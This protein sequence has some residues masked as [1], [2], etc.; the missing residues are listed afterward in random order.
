MRQHAVEGASIGDVF[1]S[2][3]SRLTVLSKRP[4]TFV[5]CKSSIVSPHSPLP[6]RLSTRSEVKAVK[7]MKARL[8]LNWRLVLFSML[9]ISCSGCGKSETVESETTETA[10]SSSDAA[11]PAF[12]FEPHKRRSA[13]Q[14]EFP[15]PEFPDFVDVAADHGIDF[16]YDN[17]AS[18]KA[19]MVESTGGGCGWIDFDADGMTDLYLTQ[20]G[21]PC[22]DATISDSLFRQSISGSFQDRF[23]E[24]GLMDR[25]FGHGVAVGDFD[26][27]GFDDM[28]VANA[29]ENRLFRNMGDGTFIET[30]ADMQGG[31]TAWS[32]TVAW[33]DIDRD[34]DLDLYVCNYSIYDPNNP[35]ECLDK[36]GIPSI[37]HPRNVEPEPDE[38]FVNNGDGSFTESSQQLGLFG[39]GNKGLGVV[40]ADL[41]DDFW[42]D[43]YVAND[44][45]ANFMFI[46]DGTGTSFKESSLFLG[47]GYCATG[48]A[49]ASMGVGFGDYDRNGFPDLFLTHFTGEHNT[50]YRNLGPQGLQDVSGLVGLREPS[51]P[52]LAFGTVMSDFNLDGYEDLFVTNGHIDPRY[53]DGEGYEMTPQVF[54]FD[55]RNWQERPSV[56][57]DF[58]TRKAVGRAVGAADFDADGDLDLCVVHHNS[59]VALLENR[60]KVGV[61]L[62]FKL[63]GR[64]S[65]RS[66]FQAKVRVFGSDERPFVQEIAGGTSFGASHNRTLFFGVGEDTGP[67]KVKIEWPS[68]IHQQLQ[69]HDHRQLNQLVE[70]LAE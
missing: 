68:G 29:R 60:S 50:L 62:R 5:G 4:L 31:K 19:L 63:I 2:A 44:T 6:I 46:N 51:L 12:R 23:A 48:E 54:S 66:A 64:S 47:G 55:G 35:V 13:E 53:F 3:V 34:G 42:P 16:T 27:D 36:D 15:M 61:G 69:I 17:G 11:A 45:T 21:D 37:C 58:F 10:S 56:A 26:N 32:S 70:P 43:I 28:Y 9:L 52:K 41:N 39:E 22:G 57:G 33:G 24:S 67:W 30:T 38:C 1:L 7:A 40:I 25:G 14:V 49:Q 8:T 59:P 65:N 18:P 20:G